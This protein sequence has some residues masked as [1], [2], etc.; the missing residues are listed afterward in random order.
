[1]SEWQLFDP[2]T[3]PEFTTNAFFEGHPWIPPELQRGHAERIE[4]VATAVG[5]I[6]RLAA[7][8]TDL[9][10]GDGSLLAAV[11]PMVESC[12]GYDLGA[13]NIDR[14]RSRGLDVRRADILHDPLEYGDI[15]TC[16]EVIEHLLDPRAF[17]RS[18]PSHVI[19]VASSPSTETD[20]DH[21]E[22]HAWAWDLDG[23]RD[24]FVDCGW[25]VTRQ[26]D[27]PAGFQVVTAV[28]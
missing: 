13:G 12:W 14:A 19:V 1:V 5:E 6:G 21:Y 10:C 9:G 7:T 24:L 15:V 20:V 11:Q 22:H 28:R 25:R 8:L 18:L 17:L 3:V 16:T 26:R 4:M 23:Y 27:C 2:A